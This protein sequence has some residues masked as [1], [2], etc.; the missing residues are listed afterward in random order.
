MSSWGT[1]P[2]AFLKALLQQTD[3]FPEKDR[4][5]S[6]DA[7]VHIALAMYAI[8][9]LEDQGVNVELRNRPLVLPELDR[10]WRQVLHIRKDLPS[11]ILSNDIPRGVTLS[12]FGEL[13]RE[14]NSKAAYTAKSGPGGGSGDQDTD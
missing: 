1:S 8:Y 9:K 5:W 3:Y 4:D 7:A 14:P 6:I 10:A 11:E 13:L 2:D 12:K